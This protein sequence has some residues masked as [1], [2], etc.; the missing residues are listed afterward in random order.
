MNIIGKRILIGATLA[1]LCIAGCIEV[2]PLLEGGRQGPLSV[3]TN[4]TYHG[5][6]YCDRPWFSTWTGGGNRTNALFS[7]RAKYNWWYALAAVCTFGAY[8]PMDLE[9]RY[10]LGTEGGK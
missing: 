1:F 8:M 5:C 9:W 7:V 2:D 4:A 6:A 3:M 10:D